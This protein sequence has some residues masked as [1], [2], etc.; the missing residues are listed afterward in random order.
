MIE[1]IEREMRELFSINEIDVKQIDDEKYHCAFTYYDYDVR[2]FYSCVIST[3]AN[4]VAKST[5]DEFA[6]VNEIQF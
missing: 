2:V 6:I 5:F 3:N 1:L 4:D